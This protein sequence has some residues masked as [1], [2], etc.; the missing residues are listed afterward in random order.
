MMS[1][2]TA[3]DAKTLRAAITPRA[4]EFVDAHV[5]V[6]LHA[7]TGEILYY[8]EVERASS[9][10]RLVLEDAI[11][12]VADFIKRQRAVERKRKARKS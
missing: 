5:L 10:Q 12:G 1:K 2:Q 8:S 7:D 3:S 6:G 11:L 4:A 9:A